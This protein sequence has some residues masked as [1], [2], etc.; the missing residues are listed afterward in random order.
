MEEDQET[1]SRKLWEDQVSRVEEEMKEID[2]LRNGKVGKIWEVKKRIIAGKKANMQA[3]AMINPETQR[4][5]VTK[6]EILQAT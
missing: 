4:L 5:A 3:T 6:K 2:K 1:S